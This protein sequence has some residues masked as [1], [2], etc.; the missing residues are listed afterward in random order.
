MILFGIFLL[1]SLLKQVVSLFVSENEKTVFCFK[2]NNI[3]GMPDGL[4]IDQ[5]GMLWVTSWGGAVVQYTKY[6]IHFEH[7]FEQRIYIYLNVGGLCYGIFIA[8]SEE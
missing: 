7:L 2:K 8:T 5:E 4:T 3:E 1:Y 6:M